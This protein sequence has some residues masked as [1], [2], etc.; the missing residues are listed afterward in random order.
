MKVIL[1][2]NI[3]NKGKRG[4]IITVADSYAK[5]VLIK[6]GEA[7][8]ATPEN[9]NNLKLAQKKSDKDEACAIALAND[10]KKMLE[11]N[12]IHMS[13]KMGVAG[14]AYGSI[15]SQHIV[16][17][18]DKQLGV[19]VNKKTIVMNDAIVLPGKYELKVKLHRDVIATM[20]V[21]VESED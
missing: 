18:I 5:N 17:A 13:L 16:D 12:V 4:D 10:A 11:S 9:L 14:K 20:T 7:V 3:K 15:T 19:E 2:K 21:W 8:P 1:Q 6:K